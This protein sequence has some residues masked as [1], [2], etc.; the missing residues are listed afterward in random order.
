MCFP[1]SEADLDAKADVRDGQDKGP[2]DLPGEE[3]NMQHVIRGRNNDTVVFILPDAEQRLVVAG[4][5]SRLPLRSCQPVSN[6]RIL[7]SLL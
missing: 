2:P 6:H 5:G 3:V 7:S 4:P 1:L